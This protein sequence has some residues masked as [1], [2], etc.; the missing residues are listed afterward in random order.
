MVIVKPAKGDAY[1]RVTK[2]I[3]SDIPL[4]NEKARELAK[5]VKRVRNSNHRL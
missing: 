2:A 1:E 4:T 3:F 5:N